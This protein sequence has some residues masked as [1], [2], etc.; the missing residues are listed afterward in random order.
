MHITDVTNLAPGLRF[1]TDIAS[2]SDSNYFSDFAVGSDQTSVTFLERRAEI[3]YYDDIWR[4]RAQAQ[5]FQTI[6]TGD[7][8]RRPPLFARAARRGLWPASRWS[9]QLEFAL[10]SEVTN[11]LREVG[12]TGV[13]AD[14]SPELRWSARERGL[15][16][17]AR[18][19]LPLHAVRP[20]E[21]GAS[22]IRARPP[23]RCRMRAWTPV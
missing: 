13:R 6:D 3:L 7:R 2:V 18:G 1:D 8:C 20:A 15:F 17:R 14:I 4:I 11:F 5:N 16:L 10:S 9:A 12:P 21:C 22:A 19:R 23:A